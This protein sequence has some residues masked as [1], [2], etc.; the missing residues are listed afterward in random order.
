MGKLIDVR[1]YIILL[2]L[3]VIQSCVGFQSFPNVARGGDTVTLAVGSIDGMTKSNSSAVFESYVDGTITALP[4]RSIVKIRPDNTSEIATFDPLYTGNIEYYNSHSPWLVLAIIDLPQG[5]TVG[6]GEVRVT[7]AGSINI[8]ANVNQYPIKI[9]IIDGI[10]T[11]NSFD[12]YTGGGASSTTGNISRLEPQQQVVIRPPVISNG[13]YNAGFYGAAEI[14]VSVPTQKT[15]GGITGLYD[16][17]VVLDDM[18]YTHNA[19]QTNMIW[20][21]D[22]DI[23]TIYYVSPKASMKFYSTR[24]SLVLKNGFEFIGTPQILSVTYFDADGNVKT[25]ATPTISDYSITVEN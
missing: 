10:G 12:Y 15:G 9:E 11:A 6:K 22:G 5:L 7:S 17:K 14:K 8:G 3:L 25:A 4:I 13:W 20:S 16:V 18:L 21:R 2:A 23:Y 1:V 24:V 19:S